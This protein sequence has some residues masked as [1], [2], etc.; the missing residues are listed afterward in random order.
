MTQNETNILCTPKIGNAITQVIS[1]KGEWNKNWSKTILF[2][3][4]EDK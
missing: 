4:T 1:N 2:Q 3:D